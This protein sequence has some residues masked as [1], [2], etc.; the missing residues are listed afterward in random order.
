MKASS[1]DQRTLLELADI[2]RRLAHAT[3]Q[4]K[5]PPQAARIAELSAKR[6]EQ[7]H[8]LTRRIGV[9]EDAATEL[10]RVESDI[11]TARARIERDQQRM[12][13]AGAKDAVALENEVVSLTGRI[14]ALEATQLELM[15]QLEAA[16]A[17][18]NEQQAVIAE[19]NAE[20]ARLSTE[21]KE[22]LASSGVIIAQ[23]ERVLDSVR[24]TVPETLLNVYQRIARNTTGAGLFREGM[25]EACRV[26]LTAT[27][28]AEVRKAPDDEVVFCPECSAILVRTHESW[29]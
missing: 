3:A 7:S 1:A 27:D 17:A 19:I 21:A 23:L 26:I 22:L 8:E 5:N 2:E 9:R 14:E 25:C 13:S 11:A 6:Q 18:A 28:V 16:E 12:A 29:A 4:R 15:E 20:G 24:A 10:A